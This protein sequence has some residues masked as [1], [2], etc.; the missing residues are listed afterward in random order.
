MTTTQTAPNE[1]IA[2]K[3]VQVANGQRPADDRFVSLSTHR[4]LA[5]TVYVVAVIDGTNRVADPATFL[6]TPI[7]ER[8]RKH[9]NRLTQRLGKVEPTH[10][11]EHLSP[12]NPQ[13]RQYGIPE[14]PRRIAKG[15]IAYVEPPRRNKYGRWH[16]AWSVVGSA[17]EKS[18]T[19]ATR[20]EADTFHTR[21]L[22]EWNDQ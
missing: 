7:Y 13:R 9:A 1:P 6:A 14:R 2:N 5:T 21:L 16:V 3:R 18:R 20:R 11:A 19:F 10:Y 17:Q 15:P 22:N 4:L 12:T 8:A